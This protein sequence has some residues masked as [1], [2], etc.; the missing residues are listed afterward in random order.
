MI[1][2]ARKN[3]S[4]GW[5]LLP[6]LLL[7]ASTGCEQWCKRNYCPE[8]L[9]PQRTKLILK[10]ECVGSWMSINNQFVRNVP[11]RDDW[12]GF[13]FQLGKFNPNNTS[14]PSFERISFERNGSEVGSLDR[15]AFKWLN[16][17]AVPSNVTPP[18]SIPIGHAEDDYALLDLNNRPTGLPLLECDVVNQCSQECQE[19]PNCAEV[20]CYSPGGSST[21]GFIPKGCLRLQRLHP[22]I[23]PVAI[24]TYWY[25]DADNGVQIKTS[26]VGE[27]VRFEFE[28]GPNL[29]IE[30]DGQ[31]RTDLENVDEIV[32]HE[33]PHGVIQH[34]DH[35]DP[36]WGGRTGT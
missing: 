30:V 28:L 20:A 8:T 5:L 9:P 29:T 2:T 32:I 33:S 36:P 12:D 34:G 6:L 13:L 23:N 17:V 24:V 19:D 35:E 4:L 15:G 16:I 26:G 1:F 22:S 3:Q 11:N 10:H 18:P 25:W 7:A 21:P 14:Y 27:H 31:R